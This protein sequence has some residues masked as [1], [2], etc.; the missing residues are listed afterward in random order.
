[1]NSKILVIYVSQSGSTE[2]MVRAAAEGAKSA[3]AE[4]IIKEAGEATGADVEQ[5]DALIWGSGNYY[6]Y[7]HGRLK[8]WF[9][10]EHMRL[11]KKSKAGEMKPRPYFCCS[12]AS[13]N[14]YR[15]L[16][17]IERLSTSMNLKKA[18]EPVVSKGKPTDEVLAQCYARGCDL[19]GV[20]VD[21]MVDLYVPAPLSA[22]PERG[23]VDQQAAV[24]V[25]VTLPGTEAGKALELVKSRLPEFDVRLA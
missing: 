22:T 20:N 12:S 16:P 3:G 1:M 8:E 6:G 14:P 4:V 10:R 15:H 25:V 13:A 21:G 7:M 11:S 24:R 17:P 5:C 18:F 2:L 23:K 19:V 9:D